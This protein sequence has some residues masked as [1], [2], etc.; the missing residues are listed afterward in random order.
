[1]TPFI[2]LTCGW[3]RKDETNRYYLNSNYVN[4]VV[5]AGGVPVLLPPL[6][7]AYDPKRLGPLLD[8]L[9]GL[10]LTGGVDLDPVHYGEEPLPA[11]GQIDP[12]R[13]RWELALAKWALVRGMPVL[14]ICRGIQVLNVAAGGS[15]YQDV[16]SQVQPPSSGTAVLHYQRA[17][18]WYPTH[19]V[20][21]YDGSR[22]REIFGCDCL[23]VNSFHHQAVKMPG[24]D[25]VVTARA[26]DGV[27]EAIESAIHPFAVGVQWHP[28]CMWEAEP[29]FLRLFSRLVEE[30]KAFSVRQ[31]R[32]GMPVSEALALGG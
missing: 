17:P 30:A 20:Q 14:G 9:S 13:D 31:A 3:Q 26:A 15:L 10:L 25:M 11:L 7:K 24:R 23:R 12:D 22:L 16:A 29:I 2:G 8:L 5:A 1:M 28:E 32:G 6:S 18:E 19:A 27:I 21:I 4:A